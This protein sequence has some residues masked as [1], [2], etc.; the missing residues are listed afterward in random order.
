MSIKAVI[1]DLDGTLLDTIDD[2]ADSMNQA[3]INQGRTPYDVE[4][5]KIFVGRGVDELVKAVLKEDAGNEVLFNTVR[6]DYREY[7]RLWQNQKTKPYAG[8]VTLLQDLLKK[9]IKVC[10][11]SNKPDADTVKV[12]AYYFPNYP[13]FEV[14]GQRSGYPVK[15]DP[16]S[17]LEIVGKLQFQKEEILYIGDTMT[18]M[19]T[20]VNAQLTAIGVLWGFRQK[21]E[22]LKGGASFIISHPSEL[23]QLIE[24][25]G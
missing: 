17:V 13:F 11:L 14:Y 16:K 5:Y 3:L 12:I 8:I 1:F 6:T 15:P 19:Q 21:D 10:V 2:I 9:E 18:D 25:R 23:T 20:A 24:K 22:L 4:S 7:Y